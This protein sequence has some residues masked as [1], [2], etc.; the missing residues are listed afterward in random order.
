MVLPMVFADTAFKANA[1]RYKSPNATYD[2]NEKIA[3]DTDF[4]LLDTISNFDCK[5]V[6]ICGYSKK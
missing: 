1:H 3:C 2:R 6:N 5:I 4:Y